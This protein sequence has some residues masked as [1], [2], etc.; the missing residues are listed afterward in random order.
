M[1]L[2]L[3][4]LLTE[5]ESPAKIIT[6]KI[7]WPV[8]SQTEMKWQLEQKISGNSS[9]YVDQNSQNTFNGNYC[10]IS[11]STENLAR[12]TSVFASKDVF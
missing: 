5:N 2:S 4:L 1:E 3:P 8:L 6:E 7:N 10:P 12:V 9:H 11:F